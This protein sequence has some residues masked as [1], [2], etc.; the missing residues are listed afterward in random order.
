MTGLKHTAQRAT[1]A[2]YTL[3]LEPVVKYLAGLKKNPFILNDLTAFAK[4]QKTGS[5]DTL[6]E[7]A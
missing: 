6:A 7:V 2:R 5:Q 1:I 4:D 3:V